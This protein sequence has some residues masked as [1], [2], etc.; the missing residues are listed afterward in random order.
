M[1]ESPEEATFG[2][3]VIEEVTDL[4]DLEQN[5]PLVSNVTPK[6]TLIDHPNVIIT[7]NQQVNNEIKRLNQNLVVG[8][9]T[10]LIQTTDGKL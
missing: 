2:G 4:E 3:A 8:E 1:V 5:T 7:S 9:Q 10:A 6:N